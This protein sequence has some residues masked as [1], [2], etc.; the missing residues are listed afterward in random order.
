MDGDSDLEYSQ[1]PISRRG[2]RHNTEKITFMRDPDR[3]T[4]TEFVLALRQRLIDA[5]QVND[6]ETIAKL[7]TTFGMLVD[8]SYAYQDKSVMELFVS[9]EDSAR[10]AAMNVGWKAPV[11]S[12]AAIEDALQRES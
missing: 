4:L 11:P 3:V 6:Q 9:L 5:V 2:G 7:L 1:P 10:N 8:T 12:I